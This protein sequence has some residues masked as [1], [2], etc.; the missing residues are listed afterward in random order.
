MN[1]QDITALL[2]FTKY[3]YDPDFLN[4]I[5]EVANMVR[6]I[7]LTNV[8]PLLAAF[9]I[10]RAVYQHMAKN[11]GKPGIELGEV[12]RIFGMIALVAISVELMSGLSTIINGVTAKFEYTRTQSLDEF[13]R[14]TT[15]QQV[16]TRYRLTNEQTD[17]LFQDLS[18]DVRRDK[19]TIRRYIDELKNSD[20]PSSNIISA[21]KDTAIKTQHA[22]EDVR[23]IIQNLGYQILSGSI[24]LFMGLVKTAMGAIIFVFGIILQVL[25]PLAFAF[26]LV[27][28][29][30]AVKFIATWLSVKFAF[31][32]FLIVES[33]VMGF[34]QLAAASMTSGVS[35]TAAYQNMM[36][37]AYVV[38]IAA[39]LLVFW[40]TSQYVGTSQVGAFLSK[41]VGA[42]G[43]LA[44]N[45][46][47]AGQAAVRKSKKE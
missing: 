2:D 13:Q 25:T 34:F 32:T 40:F 37:V 16:Q 45:A 10:C 35:F 8:V 11:N 20:E 47:K 24:L 30:K 31:L 15:A 33:V 21:V 22:I 27:F 9:A 4:I 6:T 46:L 18:G 39:F 42:A 5:D 17:D 23:S 7:A 12:F 14:I 19:Q 1:V 3:F 29:G 36:L 44:N 28:P 26:E 43:M 41:T 38:A